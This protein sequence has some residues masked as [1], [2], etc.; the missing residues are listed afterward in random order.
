MANISLKQGQFVTNSLPN[1]WKF[2]NLTKILLRRRFIVLGVS[3]MVISAT[4]FTAITNKPTYKSQMQILVS[5]NVSEEV[6]ITN[7]NID[8]PISIEQYSVQKNL[9]QSSKLIDKVVNLLSFDYPNITKENILGKTENSENSPLKVTQLETNKG[10]KQ[11]LSPVFEISFQDNDPLKTKKVLLALQ[12]VYQ[13]YNLERR[14][15]RFNQGLAFINARLPVI[16][17]QLRQA[18]RKLEQFRKKHNLLDPELQSQVLIKSLTKTQ[19]QL[20]LTRTQLQDINSRYQNLEERITEASQKALVSMRLAQSSRYK[21][22]T[23]ELQKTEQSLAKEQLRY[24]DDSPIVQSLKQQRRSQLTL[25]RQ[26]LKRLTA[27]LKTQTTPEPEQLVGVDPNLVEEFV[28]VQTTALGLIANEKSLRESEQRIRSELSKYPSLIAEYQRL[29]PEVETQRKTLEQMLQAQQSMGMKIAHGGFDWLVLEEANLGTY[30]GNDRFWLVF[31][32]MIT[33]PILGV[34]LALIWGMRHRIIHSAQDLQKVSNLRL[35]GTVPKLAPRTMEKRLPNLSWLGGRNLTESEEVGNSWLPCHETLDMVYQNTQIL[36]YPFPFKSMM[37]TSA[38]PGEGRTTLAMGLA[39]SAAHMHRR[40]L[41]IDANLRSPKLHKILQLSNDWGLSLLLL[42]E[43]NTEVQDYIQPIHPS[44]DI[45]TAGPT[46][47]DAV[48]LLSSQRLKDLIE[49]FE[50]TYDLVLIDA[51][52][53]LGTVD[54]RIVASYCHGIMM[55]GR[56]GWVT[57][58]EL[59]QA[60]EILNSLNLVGIIANDMSSYHKG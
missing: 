29:L 46:P 50:E 11:V 1:K 10:A 33:G 48:E 36:K 9:M 19:E 45:L 16:K 5:P 28:Q 14:Q 41:L 20:Q 40:V 8:I 58:T 12:K 55:V 18:E 38:L 60:V 17:Q 26:E 56:I 7:N 49:L 35:L 47:E 32:G 4:S 21:T 24:T 37:V 54:G 22:L 42:D 31:V 57:Q 13:D 52:P 2:R 44:I 30:V 23:S 27:E 25:V 39:A 59:T 51:P 15:E 53:I 43:T 6:G 3:C 34:V